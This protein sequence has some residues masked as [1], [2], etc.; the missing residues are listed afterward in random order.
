[1]FKTIYLHKKIQ[2]IKIIIV[3]TFFKIIIYFQIIN[4]VIII[5][6]MVSITTI[7]ISPKIK[8]PIIIKII[9]INIQM[10]KMPI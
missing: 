4:I 3:I 5:L 10:I 7:N 9:K 8:F 2:A 6:I 1:M